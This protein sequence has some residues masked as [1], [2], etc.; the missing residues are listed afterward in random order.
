MTLEPVA[1]FHAPLPEKFGIPRQSGLVPDLLGELQFLEGKWS[2]EA[3]RG[4]EDFDYLWLIWGFSL[5][6]G[7]AEVQAGQTAPLTVRPPRLGGNERMGV[8]ATRS[9]FRPNPLGLSS[10]R[11]LEV[12]AAHGILRVGGA[13]LADGTPVYDVKP[14]I[15]YTDSH[16]GVRAGFTDETAWETLEVEIPDAC[17]A[18]LEPEMQEPLRALLAQDPR[19]SYQKGKDARDYALSYA[20]HNVRFRVEGKRL[21]VTEI[22]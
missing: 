22:A 21:I 8:Y 19:P 1:L 13:D 7:K 11:L 16:P 20:G 14:Y 15:P 6:R 4:L 17:A 9:P 3:F 2:P 10:V 5:N 12:D 18:A